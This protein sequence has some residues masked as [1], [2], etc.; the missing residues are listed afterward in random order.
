MAKSIFNKLKTSFDNLSSSWNDYP[1]PQ[2]KRDSYFSLCG[3][4][5]LYVL[6]KKSQKSFVGDIVVP[7]SP[8]SDLSNVNRTLKKGESWIY[9][10]IFDLP[11]GF[12]EYKVILH[13]GAVDQICSVHLN[14]KFVGENVGGYLPFE[15]DVTPFL[16]EKEN[17][18][19]VRVLDNLDANLGYGKQRTKRGGM[20]YTPISG[21]WQSVWLESVPK[22]YI[23]SI[24]I[25][26]TLDSVN[27]RVKGGDD[28]KT[29]EIEGIE[30]PFTFT[31]D[32]ITINIPSPVL[33]TPDNPHLYNFKLTSGSDSIQ[34]YFALRTISINKINGNAKIFLNDAP[35][36]FHGVLDQGY[37]PDGIYTP[38]SP[39]GFK[40]DIMKMKSLGFNTLRKHIKIEPDL[41][42]YYCDK[43]GMIVFQ[44][45][46]NS[47]KYSYLFDTVIPT[48][49]CKKNIEKRGTK[50]QREYFEKH[51]LKTLEHLYNHPSVCY[52]TIFNEGWGQHDSDNYYQKFKVI[53]STRIYDTTSG[54]FEKKKSDVDSKHV[55]FKKLN[56]SA[57]SD[58]PLI[59]S[60]FGGY[61]Y[62]V[63]GHV[64]NNQKNY[65]YQTYK[66]LQELTE[67]IKDL[68]L[69]Q[70]LSCV[71]RGVNGDIITQLSDIEDEINGFLSYDRQVCKVDEKVM[72]DIYTK[73]NEAF[74]ESL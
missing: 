53:D 33:W 25:T 70:L 55:Y 61:A 42:Y 14:G 47:G 12:A 65:G 6:S 4:W 69:N 13:F 51:S 43:L 26:P 29:I 36:Y 39:Q 19:E 58:R 18:L 64:F 21:I 56:L 74:I 28:Q 32:Q 16:A 8:E 37:Y 73:L 34:S 23:E 3:E 62:K 15:F 52:Y 71:K 44:D 49:L 59:I 27:I 31:G 41:F 40:F 45:M 72:V 30:T 50:K 66:S 38:S 35:F 17:V 5:E 63:D 2:F 24:K 7:F 20:W 57:R 22:N 67:G 60:E 46:V 68:Y 11:T 54:W 48:I 1:R 9:K 10:K